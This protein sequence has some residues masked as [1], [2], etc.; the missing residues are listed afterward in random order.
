MDDP[1]N[2][3]VILGSTGSVGQK[4]L[5]VIRALS[6]RFKIIGLASG[7]N[8]ELLKAQIEEFKPEMIY[9]Q[10]NLGTE[11]SR[12]YV[13]L[14]QMASHPEVDLVVVAIPG[15]VG[16]FPTMAALSSSKTV[17]L[18][19]KEVLVM[20]GELIIKEA[21][22]YNARLNPIDSEHSAIWQCLKGEQG[23]PRRIFLTASGGPFYHHS[24]TQLS[25]VT[26]NE[27]LHHPVWNMGAK[28]SIDS[29]TLMNKGLEAIEAH[30]LFAIPF[31]NIEIL[32]HPQCVIHSMVEF[33]DGSIKAQV[34]FPDMRLPIQYALCYPERLSNST[35]PQFNFSTVPVLTFE[36]IKINN[37]PCLK[38]ALEAGTRGGTYPAVLCA[39]DEVAVELFLSGRIKFIDIPALI[40]E[41]LQRHQVID[42]PGID[43]ILQ[44]DSWARNY[45]QQLGLHRSTK[46]VQ[47]DKLSSVE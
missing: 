32:F 33:N 17:A 39:A 13:S 28:V 21:E 18:A 34:G 46:Y 23:K 26:V 12:K 22:R 24:R 42:S 4:T 47:K 38:L 29:A 41:T 16:L 5:E 35:I 11:Y 37:F 45:V 15:K 3:L 31:E 6:P 20:A 14:E 25:K 2:K 40:E 1:I 44:V 36:P 7:L 27:A 8:I 9:S 19:S 43:D 30:C 10:L